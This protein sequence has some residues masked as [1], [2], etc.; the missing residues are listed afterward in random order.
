MQVPE[1]TLAEVREPLTQIL[2][3][4]VHPRLLI[5]PSR[6]QDTAS[7]DMAEELVA[8]PIENLLYCHTLLLFAQS[9][10]RSRQDSEPLNITSRWKIME[11]TI[12]AKSHNLP[13]TEG[14][15]SWGERLRTQS[16]WRCTDTCSRP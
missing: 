1:V 10:G 15:V 5:F 8:S 9:P 14:E 13:V 11:G 16:K 6:L 4:L 3:G 2:D 7:I 12:D